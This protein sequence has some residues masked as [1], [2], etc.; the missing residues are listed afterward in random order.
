[1]R[2]TSRQRGRDERNDGL[3]PN[4]IWHHS[5]IRRPPFFEMERMMTGIVNDNCI[6]CK[7]TDCVAVCPVDRFYEGENMLIIHPD[8]C[9]FRPSLMPRRSNTLAR[10]G[11][12]F[13]CIGCATPERI[14]LN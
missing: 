11:R 6:K 12:A 8:E 10:S 1:M 3:A 4:G 14:E 5:E 9:S 2:P 7:Y 13:R